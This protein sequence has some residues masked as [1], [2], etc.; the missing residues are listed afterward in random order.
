MI[1]Y[2]S[3]GK[4]EKISIGVFVKRTAVSGLLRTIKLFR[5][6]FPIFDNLHIG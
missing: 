6:G 2:E 5:I 4:I 1:D 3:Q